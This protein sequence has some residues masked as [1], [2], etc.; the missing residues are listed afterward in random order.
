[1]LDRVVVPLLELPREDELRVVPLLLDSRVADLL[2]VDV[3]ELERVVVPR[4]ELP[5]D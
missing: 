1:M 2:P 3:P 5:D 4:L